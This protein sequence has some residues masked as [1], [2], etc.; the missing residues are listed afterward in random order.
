M[1]SM[2]KYCFGCWLAFCFGCWHGAW[3]PKQADSRFPVD[4]GAVRFGP[5]MPDDDESNEMTD[6]R[7]RLKSRETLEL[8]IRIANVSSQEYCARDPSRPKPR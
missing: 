8:P 5:A 4:R 2:K 3:Q 7:Q 1:Y 6:M